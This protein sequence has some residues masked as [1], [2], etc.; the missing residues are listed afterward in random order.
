MSTR[1]LEALVLED[2]DLVA[3]FIE[4]VLLA[5][6]IG[7]DCIS[8]PGRFDYLLRRRY[9]VA[10]IGVETPRR[11]MHL[12]AEILNRR[13]IPFI[14]FCTSP[15]S[16]RDGVLKEFAVSV[17]NPAFPEQLAEDVI[18]EYSCNLVAERTSE[19]DKFPLNQ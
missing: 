18:R 3:S 1:F 10:V 9:D 2:D 6:N 14:I 13:R 4:D 7:S 8:L 5:R 11:Y 19:R 15:Q 17:Y 16:P 12:S